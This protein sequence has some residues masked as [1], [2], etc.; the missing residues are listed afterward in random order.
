MQCGHGFPYR[1]QQAGYV[2]FLFSCHRPPLSSTIR[3]AYFV[4]FSLHPWCITV[5]TAS[6]SPTLSY[7]V[8]CGMP[9]PIGAAV[10]QS[11]SAGTDCPIHPCA[12]VLCVKSKVAHTKVIMQ[13]KIVITKREAATLRCCI[14]EYCGTS[15]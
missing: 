8:R 12:N 1:S 5:A 9:N 4:E 7:L 14:D 13:K 10:C 6:F 2:S 3:L 11:H 15:L